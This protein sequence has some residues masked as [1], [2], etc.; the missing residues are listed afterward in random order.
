VPKVLVTVQYALERA[1]REAYLVYAREMRD[2]AV[3]VLGLDYRIYEDD[4]HPGRFTELFA[5]ASTEEYE[6]LEEKQDDTFR[7]FVARL[8]RYADLSQVRYTALRQVT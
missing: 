1:K 3:A 6:E 4:D 5:C 7:G 8:E 2:H